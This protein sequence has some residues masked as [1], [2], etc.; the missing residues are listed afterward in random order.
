MTLKR[1]TIFTTRLH[2]VRVKGRA[3]HSGLT[4][5]RFVAKINAVI[6]KTAVDE[7]NN[8]VRV[9]FRVLSVTPPDN[10]V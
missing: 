9:R 3:S 10:G 7:S 6:R 1:K 2:S 4:K 5:R 8:L